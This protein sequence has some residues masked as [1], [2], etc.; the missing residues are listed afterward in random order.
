V[1]LDAISVSY[2]AEYILSLFL[3]DIIVKENK[4]IRTNE[5]VWE[6]ITEMQKAR[7]NENNQNGDLTT[8]KGVI[9][10]AENDK[11]DDGN[12][13]FIDTGKDK[14]TFG[15]VTNKTEALGLIEEQKEAMVDHIQEMQ[16][17]MNIKKNA[18]AKMVGLI[19]CI[20]DHNKKVRGMVE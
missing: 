7:D 1:Q 2:L 16:K 6:K 9:E 5:R 12:K 8:S 15:D 10:V 18:S 19:K 4:Q 13:L 3:N 20:D 17:V 11:D 14:K